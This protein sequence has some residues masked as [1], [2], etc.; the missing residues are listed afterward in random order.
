MLQISK[1]KMEARLTDV[2]VQTMPKKASSRRVNSILLF[3]KYYDHNWM[4]PLTSPMTKLPFDFSPAYSNGKGGG[5]LCEFLG[6]GVQMGPRGRSRGRVQG[7][8]IPPEM[9]CS[10]LI[11]R[12]FCK[13]KKVV[14]WCWSRARDECTP[15]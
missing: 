3:H 4:H 8:P 6:G 12:V 10:F 15:S 1:Y 7:V 9:T 13:K 2:I 14:Y 11:Q 5:V